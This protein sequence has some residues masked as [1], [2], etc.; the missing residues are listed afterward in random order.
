MTAEPASMPGSAVWNK[1]GSES[2]LRFELKYTGASGRDHLAVVGRTRRSGDAAE[3][4]WLKALK[5]PSF[6][7]RVQ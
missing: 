6:R 4:V 1:H 7:I 3:F 2:E 5:G